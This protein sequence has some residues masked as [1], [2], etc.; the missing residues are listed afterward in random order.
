[1]FWMKAMNK[2]FGWRYA[3]FKFGRGY[4]FARIHKDKNGNDFCIK[5]GLIINPG[6]KNREWREVL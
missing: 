1:M 6:G 4:E 3:C 2:L 5:Y